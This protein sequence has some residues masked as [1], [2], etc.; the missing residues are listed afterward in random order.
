MSRIMY[1]TGTF[2]VYYPC[3]TMVGTGTNPSWERM[4]SNAGSRAASTGYW[5]TTPTV[6]MFRYIVSPTPAGG[7]YSC[8]G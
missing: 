6:R 2:L 1:G 4:I 8:G 5:M 7:V 3:R